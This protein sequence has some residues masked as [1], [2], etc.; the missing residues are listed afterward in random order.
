MVDILFFCA[1]LTGR[2]EGHAPFVQT[3]AETCD[4]GAEAVKRDQGSSW[5]GHSG[6][7]VPVSGM[8][9]QSLL[10]LSVHSPFHW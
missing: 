1:T 2:T 4:T 9:T 10:G 7:M 8:K 6:G 5:E 3:A